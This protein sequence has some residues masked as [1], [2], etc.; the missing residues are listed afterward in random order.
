M[1]TNCRLGLLRW[2][3]KASHRSKCRLL[4]D[5][6][7]NKT[8]QFRII[9][10]ESSCFFF[11]WLMRL[12]IRRGRVN[13]RRNSFHGR[14]TA[15]TK[16]F[17]NLNDAE[18]RMRL[19]SLCKTSSFRDKVL[20]SLYGSTCLRYSGWLLICVVKDAVRLRFYT[21]KL[22]SINRSTL[23]GRGLDYQEHE[24]ALVKKSYLSSSTDDWLTGKKS[25]VF[26][27]WRHT[28]CS[29]QRIVRI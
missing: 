21:Y 22:T 17:P 5:W 2:S 19:S 3:I 9:G 1:W 27:I 28:S 7:E 29:S 20:S 15:S 23:T 25:H 18:L 10:L 26:W 14:S 6:V 11:L 13:G 16:W 12:I 4:N 8:I 24:S